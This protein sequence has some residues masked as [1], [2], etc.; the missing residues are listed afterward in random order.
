[1]TNDCPFVPQA[2]YYGGKENATPTTNQFDLCVNTAIQ[3]R[4]GCYTDTTAGNVN[5]LFGSTATVGSLSQ[6]KNNFTH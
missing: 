4:L 5:G 2:T 3:Q 1:M 6:L